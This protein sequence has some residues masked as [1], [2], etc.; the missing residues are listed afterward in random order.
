[1]N[2]PLGL[3]LSRKALVG[4]LVVAVIASLLSAAGVGVDPRGATAATTS[5]PAFGTQFHGMWSDYSDE[6]RAA[7]L[8]RLKAAGATWVRL[9]VGW[10]MLQPTSGT[11][12]SAWGVSFVDRVVTMAAQRGLKVNMMLWLTPGWANGN[13]G[14]R[15]LPDSPA[16]YARVAEWAA[17]RYAGKVQA[18]EIWNEENSSSFLSPPDPVA[19]TRLLQAAYPA[20]KRGNPSATVVF[21]GLMYNDDAWLARAYAAGAAG[22]YD[23]MAVHPYQGKADDPPEAADDG[24]RGTMRHVAAIRNLMVGNGDADKPV[25]FTEFGWSTHANT[26][27]TP[28]WA[29]GV[30]E[31]QQ[32]DYLVRTLRMVRA[33]YPYVTNV[34]WYNERQKASGNAH[35][36]GYGLLTRDAQPRPAYT[37]AANHLASAEYLGL[38]T[39]LLGSGTTWAY[40]DDGT[41]QGTAWRAQAFDDSRWRRGAA[42]LGYGDGDERTRVA[43]GRISYYMRRTFTVTN[44]AAFTTLTLKLL[45]DDGAV[46]FVNGAEVH[47]SNMPAGTVT[48]TTRAST[49]VTGTAERRWQSVSLSPRLLRSGTN[50]IAVEVHND[51]RTSSD[52]SFDLEVLAS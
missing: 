29:R 40:K 7:V 22:D 6:Q 1:M 39:S 28:Y 4:G 24:T 26:S 47:R 16:D 25:W 31:A 35:Q 33:D 38:P 34:F 37:A 14:E 8:D 20:I 46:V 2:A 36:D 32:A 9:D 48:Y 5:T 27:T 45:R 17:A 21:G 13:K 18:F 50:T 10:A 11:A 52:L 42:Q 12:Y 19:Y 23:V 15:V 3:S 43:P 44:P 30:T 41:N 51:S 49:T